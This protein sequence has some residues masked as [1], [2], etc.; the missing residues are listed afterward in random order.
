LISFS[1]LP[2]SISFD[3]FLKMQFLGWT[4]LE[5]IVFSFP[6][7]YQTETFNLWSLTASS[8]S[9]SLDDTSD[10]E[11]EIFDLEGFRH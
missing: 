8:T 10:S 11:S 1:W 2:F 6:K 5:R 3:L 7:I 9:S 4:A